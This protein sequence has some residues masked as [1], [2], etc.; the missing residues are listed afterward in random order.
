[1]YKRAIFI[2]I[3]VNFFILFSIIGI[4]IQNNRLKNIE[5]IEKTVKSITDEAIE[6]S[7]EK[8]KI[9]PNT[10]LILKKKYKACGHTIG[11]RASIPEEMVNLTK[12]EIIEQYSNWELE[13]FSR[14]EVILLKEVEGVCGEHYIL[15]EQDGYISIYTVDEN[16]NKSLKEIT[17]IATEYLTE[18]D[19]IA[20]KNEI[21]IYGIE[22]LNK[23]L[24]DFET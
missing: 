11:N 18:T 15:K 8:E 14:E 12:E 20:L 7:S 24:E 10:I 3:F 19:R 22:N 13:K 17:N 4:L 1:M 16:G 23:T 5:D 21:E 2:L 6:T 9:T